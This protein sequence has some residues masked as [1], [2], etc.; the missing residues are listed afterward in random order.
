MLAGQAVKKDEFRKCKDSIDWDDA[1]E[2]A[3]AMRSGI[4]DEFQR[5]T[6]KEG[7]DL[8]KVCWRANLKTF[9]G[10]K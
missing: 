4:K 1:E 8:E 9:V 6:A 7:R 10:G 5:A 2:L 3:K